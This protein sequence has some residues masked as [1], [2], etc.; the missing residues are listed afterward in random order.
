M[1]HVSTCHKQLIHCPSHLSQ[2]SFRHAGRHLAMAV[3][4]ATSPLAERW[5][6]VVI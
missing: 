4:K 2:L 6:I 3:P 5:V 1:Y